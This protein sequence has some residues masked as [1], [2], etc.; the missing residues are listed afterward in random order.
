MAQ[1]HNDLYL[2]FQDHEFQ[3]VNISKTVRDSEKFARTSFTQVDI[4][5]RMGPLRMLY[6]VILTRMLRSNNFVIFICCKRIAQDVD[7]HDR[8]ASTRMAR[9]GVALVGIIIRNSICFK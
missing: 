9:R 8:F 2:R 7:V 5:Q 1:L 3:N 6:S 4:C